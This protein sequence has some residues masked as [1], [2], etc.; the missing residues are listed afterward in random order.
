VVAVTTIAD[1]ATTIYFRNG[2]VFQDFANGSFK[3]L[4]GIL[5]GNKQ[6]KLDHYSKLDKITSNSQPIKGLESNPRFV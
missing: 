5:F 2:I 6:T 1:V 4:D 3:L